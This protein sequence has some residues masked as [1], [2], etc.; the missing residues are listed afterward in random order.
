MYQ[1]NTQRNF[2]PYHFIKVKGIVTVCIHVSQ[3][4]VNHWFQIYKKGYS[5]KE[6]VDIACVNIS[7]K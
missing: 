4:L 3:K 2:S 7:S 1:T 6:G 5:L